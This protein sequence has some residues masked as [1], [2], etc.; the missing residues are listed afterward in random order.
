MDKKIDFSVVVPVFNGEKSLQELYTRLA[1]TFKKMK[2]TSEV[3]FVNDGSRDDSLDILRSIKAGNDNV[4]VIDLFRNF[5]QQNAL[6]CGFQYCKGQYVITIDDDLQTPPEEIGKLY[7]KIKEGYDAVFA[8][9]KRKKDKLYKNIGSFM[10]RKITQRIFKLKNHLKFSSYKIIRREIVEELKQLKTPYPYISGMILNLTKNLANVEVEHCKRPYGK[11]NY[12]L[13]K[14]LKLSFNLM[15]HYST[16][17]LKA[18]SFLGLMVSVLSFVVGMIV[19]VR[20]LMVGRPQ[21]GWTST[22]VL[23]SF[24]ASIFFMISFVFGEYM[25]R[26]LG[27]VTREKQYSIREIIE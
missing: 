10:I 23:I 25:D 26:L 7:A 3:I 6:M 27:E 22:F 21:T 15:V 13:G 17:P 24:F 9:Y 1:G 5:G 19:L 4:I 12:S 8:T 2:K 11:S 16:F 14:L 20:K 18:I